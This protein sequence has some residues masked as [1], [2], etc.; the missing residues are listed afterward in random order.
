MHMKAEVK[1]RDH[2]EISTYTASIEMKCRLWKYVV[3]LSASLPHAKVSRADSSASCVNIPC[4]GASTLHVMRRPS[5]SMLLSKR[6][7]AEKGKLTANHACA[8]AAQACGICMA[9]HHNRCIEHAD[10]SP[11]SFPV[12]LPYSIR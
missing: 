10:V 8:H 12:R 11:P 9:W 6:D 1:D 4:H 2:N 5:A 3:V 7:M